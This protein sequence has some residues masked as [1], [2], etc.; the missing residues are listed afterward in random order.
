MIA[1]FQNYSLDYLHHPVFKAVRTV[2]MNRHNGLCQE[3]RAV[4]TEVHHQSYPKPWGS[5]DTPGNLIPL[6]HDCHCKRHGVKS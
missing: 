1:R 6:C 2:A 3:C 5:F 4:A